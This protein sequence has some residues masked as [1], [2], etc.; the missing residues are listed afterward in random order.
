MLSLLFYSRKHTALPIFQCGN[1]VPL[2]LPLE[3]KESHKYLADIEVREMCGINKD[4]HY[5]FANTGNL[6][7][8]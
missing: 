2:I 6:T 3:V 1:K 8:Y 4:N 7:P 5:I